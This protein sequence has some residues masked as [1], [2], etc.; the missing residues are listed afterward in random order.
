MVIYGAGIVG[1]HVVEKLGGARIGT[2]VKYIAVSDPNSNQSHIYG[3]P[4]VAIEELVPYRE[5][6]LVV[7]AVGEALMP[8]VRKNIQKLGF[9][10]Y[11]EWK[12]L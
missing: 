6:V 2:R 3:V 10:H 12:E 9:P 11:V 4:V 8:E 1:K 5:E 7:L